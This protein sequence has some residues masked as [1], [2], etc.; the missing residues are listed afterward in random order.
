[1]GSRGFTAEVK[2]YERDSND[3]DLPAVCFVPPRRLVWVMPRSAKRRRSTV[4]GAELDGVANRSRT[5]GCAVL[6]V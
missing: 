6:L 5:L 1:M 4:G 2:F 3:C